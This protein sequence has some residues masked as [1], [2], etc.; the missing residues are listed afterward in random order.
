MPMVVVTSLNDTFFLSSFVEGE[1]REEVLE[2]N[3]VYSRY[4]ARYLGAIVS[5][6]R[7]AE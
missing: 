2:Y 1:G 3:R 5:V 7:E 6:H 4:L